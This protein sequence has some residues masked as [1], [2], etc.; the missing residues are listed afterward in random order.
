M[1]IVAHMSRRGT[2]TKVYDEATRV[3]KERSAYPP[4]GLLF[5]VAYG[6]PDDLEFFSVWENR[7][8]WE[9]YMKDDMPAAVEESGIDVGNLD[10]YEVQDIVLSPRV[11]ATPSV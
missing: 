4:V 6:E 11:S 8:I 10:V 2:T 3:I 1:A 7:E 5:L 9:K